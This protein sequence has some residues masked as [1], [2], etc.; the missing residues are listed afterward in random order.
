MQRIIERLNG[1]SNSKGLAW[2]ELSPRETEERREALREYVESWLAADCDFKR[3][4]LKDPRGLFSRLQAHVSSAK[5]LLILDND[6]RAGIA[7]QWPASSH[8]AGEFDAAE[9]FLNLITSPVPLHRSPRLC[10]RAKCGRYF[11]STPRKTAYCSAKCAT[12]ATAV[13]STRER[14]KR[15][16]QTKLDKTQRELDTLSSHDLAGDWRRITAQRARI[17]LRFLTRHINK[18]HLRVPFGSDAKMPGRR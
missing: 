4:K 9:D 15:E 12:H 17:S 6:G 13:F 8:P 11:L 16:L 3:W 14:R 5:Y 2:P 1:E 7:A 18:K 10:R